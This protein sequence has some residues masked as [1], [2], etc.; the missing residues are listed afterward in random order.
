M[1]HERLSA[2]CHQTDRR[3][4]R[5]KDGRTDRQTDKETEGRKDRQ[6]LLVIV[7]GRKDRQTDGQRDKGRQIFE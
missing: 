3:T 2:E 7:V 4:K 5:R 1:A 6:T